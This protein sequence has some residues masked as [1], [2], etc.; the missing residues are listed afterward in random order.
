M[1]L[2]AMGGLGILVMYCLGVSPTAVADDIALGNPAYGGN[3]CPQGTASA[4]LSPDL[5]T[6]TVLFDE[7]QVEAGRQVGKTLS[8]KNCNLAIPVHIPQGLSVSI[9][10]IDYRGFVD[11]PSGARATLTAD[12]FFAGAQLGRSVNKNFLGPQSTDYSVRHE[13]MA[14][15]IVWSNC[16]DD[17]ILRSNV[18]MT[19]RTNVRQ[20]PVLATVD[21]ADL[22][23]AIVYQLQW[24]RCGL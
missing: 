13:L 21:S 6:L 22:S 19:A 4:V 1:K 12:Y 24:K 10:D 2:K 16:G 11:V 23:A 20:D 14:G 15:A 3:G 8:R 9:L 7:F 5:K 17:V 18:A